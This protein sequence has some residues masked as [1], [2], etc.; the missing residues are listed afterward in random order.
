MVI[1]M[2][3]TEITLKNKTVGHKTLYEHETQNTHFN[4]E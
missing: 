4:V 3:R 1:Y 2:V